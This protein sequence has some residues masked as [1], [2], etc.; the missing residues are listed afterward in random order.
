MGNWSGDNANI[1][2]ISSGINIRGKELSNRPK[3]PTQETLSMVKKKDLEF[4]SGM[5]KQSLRESS[6][7]IP[8]MGRES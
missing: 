5:I 3:E 7:T 1:L 2:G 8:K 4:F 6:K